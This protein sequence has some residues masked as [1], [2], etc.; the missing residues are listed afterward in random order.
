LTIEEALLVNQRTLEL[1]PD[2]ASHHAAR[3]TLLFA[4]GHL[5]EAAAS[6]DEA[7]RLDPTQPAYWAEG[8]TVLYAAGRFDDALAGYDEAARLSPTVAAHQRGRG[9]SLFALG[10]L[11]EAIEAFDAAVRLDPMSAAAHAYHA[12]ALEAANRLAEAALAAVQAISCD[13]DHVMANTVRGTIALR[14]G[15]PATAETSFLTAADAA[16]AHPVVPLVLAGAAAWARGDGDVARQ[17][18]DAALQLDPAGGGG[19][20]STWGAAEARAIAL[21]GTGRA[22]EAIDLLDRAR[23]ERR[24]GD[25]IHAAAFDALANGPVE[26]PERLDDVRKA[27]ETE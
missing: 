4:V 17:R 23:P 20:V 16:G 7:S 24:P 26:P 5:D 10:R 19:R 1:A 13:P 21:A 3:G 6:Y 14:L 8:A 27:A 11:D 15:D 2:D 18:F 12:A 9:L 25:R 22:A